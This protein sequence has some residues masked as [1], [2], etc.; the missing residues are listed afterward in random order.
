M[1]L[2]HKLEPMV[3][4]RMQYLGKMES[5]K[6][7]IFIVLYLLVK[8]SFLIF[9]NFRTN[10]CPVSKILLNVVLFQSENRGQKQKKAE[11]NT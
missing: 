6:I 5:R 10:N 3:L 8:N 4:H 1:H 7:F 11:Q 9:K 2:S